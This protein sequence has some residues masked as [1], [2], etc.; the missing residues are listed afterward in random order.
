MSICNSCCNLYPHQDM[1]FKNGKFTCQRCAKSLQQLEDLAAEE[2]AKKARQKQYIVL[3]VQCDDLMDLGHNIKEV[4]EK[5]IL[6]L[7]SNMGARAN[8]SGIVYIDG[9]S[10]D[11]SFDI[12]TGENVT[13]I[14]SVMG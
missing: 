13:N 8:C 4:V 7:V 1:A 12:L 11:Y 2:I 5:G 3:A 10:V 14:I 6:D 9:K